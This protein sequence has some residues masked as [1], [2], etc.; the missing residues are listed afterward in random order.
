MK[1]HFEWFSSQWNFD[2]LR[3]IPRT[4]RLPS[5]QIIKRNN[6]SFLFHFAMHSFVF[7]FL[8]FF[9]FLTPC[10]SLKASSP[11]KKRSLDASEKRQRS[12]KTKACNTLNGYSKSTPIFSIKT[13]FL[14]PVHTPR[15]IKGFPLG[16]PEKIGR[17]H[18]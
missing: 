3:R 1:K 7:I 17:A 18:V 11:M 9:F 8:L 5:K 10:L 15:R 12:K 6:N 2:S 16:N 13:Y 4:L 14:F